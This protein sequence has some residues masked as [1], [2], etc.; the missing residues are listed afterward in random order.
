MTPVIEVQDLSYTY[1]G[2][3]LPAV[4]GMT[5]AIE[6]GEVFGFLGPSGAGKTTTQRIITGLLHG[7]TGSVAILGTGIADWGRDLYDAIGVSFE[8]PVG[9]PRLTVAEDLTTFSRLHRCATVGVAEALEEVGLGHVA[10]EPVASLSKGMRIRLNL[11]R[12]MLHDPDIL[13]FDEPT[14]GLDPVNT[15]LV[16][17]IIDRRRA[18]GRTV[19]LTTHDMATASA[20]C[21]RV[22]FVVDGTIAAQNTP[23][24]LE[25]EHGR[26]FVRVEYRIDGE[27][28]EATLPLDDSGPELQRLVSS[29]VIETIHTAEASL[30]EVF[31]DV[32]GRSL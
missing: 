32:T 27:L 19:F 1:P 29:G 30:D 28:A 11:A 12:S 6:R 18:L 25:L 13:F 4:D 10:G 9:Y 15:K 20:T 7:W 8:L 26:R 5:F 17:E 16:R 21:D 2:R 3:S 22:A 14:S 31:V 24:A 23:R